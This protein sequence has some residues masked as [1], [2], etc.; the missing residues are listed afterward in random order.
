M[1]AAKKFR[2]QIASGIDKKLITDSEKTPRNR[3]KK[4][5]DDFVYDA[6]EVMFVHTFSNLG[7]CTYLVS[8]F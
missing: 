4:A 2:D 1:A 7:N 3:K 8:H 6:N 5:N